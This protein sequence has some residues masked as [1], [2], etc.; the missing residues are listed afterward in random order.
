M[1]SNLTEVT[2]G[3]GPRSEIG[4]RAQCPDVSAPPIFILGILPRSGTNFLFD[5]LR[6]HPDCKTAQP[7]WEDFLVHHSDLLDQYVHTVYHHWKRVDR[8][9]I[10]TLYQSLGKGLLGFLTSWNSEKRLVTK[11]PSVKNIEHFFKLFPNSFLIILIRDGR[12]VVESS[13]KSFGVSYERAIHQWAAAASVVQ[14][15]DRTT[16]HSHHQYL[17]VRYEDL[18]HDVQ[19]ELVRIFAFV[20]LDSRTYRFEEVIDLPIRGSSELRD[21]EE[22][23]LHWRGEQKKTDF[24]PMKRWSTWNRLKHERFNW[25]A[26]SYLEKFGYEQQQYSSYRLCY[27]VWN[28][29]LDFRWVLI[30][31]IMIPILQRR[32]SLYRIVRRWRA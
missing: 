28:W 18:W 27:D 6:F 29:I 11:T 2:M 22:G 25:V 7:I 20:G 23:E 8:D 26:G 1:T 10:D 17:V 14:K 5:L 31:K 3:F 30:T 13:V 32:Q 15:F 24:N 9:Q 21:Q 19:K 4:P 12:A 16:K